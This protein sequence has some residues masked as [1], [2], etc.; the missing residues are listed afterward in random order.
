MSY[1]Q[2]PDDRAS[3]PAGPPPGW[4]PDPGGLQALRWWDGAQWT[5]HTQ[6]LPQPQPPYPDAAAASPEGFS[7]FEQ[8]STGRHR[9]QSGPAYPPGLAS[10][11]YP[12][13]FPAAHPEPASTPQADVSMP[14]PAD[15]PRAPRRASRLRR[16]PLVR[17][18]AALIAFVLGWGAFR[19]ADH[20]WAGRHDNTPVSSS[21]QAPSGALTVSAHGVTLT[22]PAR[23]VNVP[24]TPKEF[25]QFIRANTAKFPHL[26]ATLKTQLSNMQELRK[27]AML[28]YR[29]NANGSITG[30]TNVL[31]EADTTPP[32]QLMPLLN[33]AVAQFGGTDEQE[34]L[35]TFGGYSGVLVT[36]IVPGQAG[37]PAQYGAQACVHGP[38]STP[39]ITVTT[40][41]AADAIATL[42][43]IADTIKFT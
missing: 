40:H 4:Y 23:W 7:P 1:Q 26:S 34:S 10:G 9:R 12:A 16:N 43:Q 33:G 42:W 17:V 22:F 27:I 11:P 24:T 19:V 21:S 5:Q 38:A 13:S 30:N 36:Y 3:A 31:I 39:I 41:G 14:D 35:T 20:L 8:E 15:S 32:S 2:P 18:A 25:A 29:V 28:V 6:P 37:H